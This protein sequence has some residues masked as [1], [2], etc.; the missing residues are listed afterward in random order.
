[1]TNTELFKKWNEVFISYFF[2]EDME[3]DAEISLFIDKDT[4]NELGQEYGLGG[5][6]GFISIIMLS[7]EERQEVY[8]EL[9]KC[10]INTSLSKEQRLKL[11]SKNIF[12]FS[13]IYID[14]NF[15]K[16]VDCPFLIYIVFIVLMG[17]ECQKN[18]KNR[19]A[20]GNYITDEL[21]KHFPNHN[22]DRTAFK[23]LFNA[24]ADQH[25]QFHA[26]GITEHPYIGLIKYQLGLSKKQVELLTKAMY[27]ADLSEEL[28]Y[29][30]WIRKIRDYVDGQ[31][32]DL[33]DKSVDEM[34]LKKRISDLRSNFDPIQ[35]ESIHQEEDIIQKGKFVLAI[36]EDDYSEEED[37]LVVLTD[38][39]NKT[40]SGGNIKIT[41]GTID[42]LGEYAEYNVNHVLI[43]GCDKAQM[44]TYSLKDG[45]NRVTS[46]SLG[47]I[48]TFSRCSNN[49]LI[50]TNFPQKGKETY[51]LVRN[52]HQEE[53]EQWLI[54]HDSPNVKE[55]MSTDR[56]LQI[57]GKGWNLFISNEIEIVDKAKSSSHRSSIIMEG[58]IRCIGK[59]KVYLRTGL[60]YFEFPEPIDEN[61][62][63]IFIAIENQGLEDEEYNYMIV[64]DNRLVIDLMNTA[65]GDHSLDIGI[66]LEYKIG[67]GKKL[68]FHEDFSVIGQDIRYSED[69]LFKMNMWGGISTEENAP[70]MKGIKVVNAKGQTDIPEGTGFYQNRKVDL[71]IHDRRFYLV[72]LIAA[73]CSMRR[74]FSITEQRLKKCIRYAATRFDINIAS[75]STFYTD[76]KYLL[77]NSGYINVDFER[78]K[79]QPVPPAF[80]KTA[81]GFDPGNNLFMLVGS[82]TQKFLC[83]LKNYCRDQY[84]SIYLHKDDNSLSKGEA[85]IPPVILLQ[86]NFS[87]DGFKK[88]TKSMFLN[89]YN[90]DVAINILKALPSYKDYESSLEHV[91]PNVFDPRIL[92][93]PDCL[94]FPRVRRSKATGYSSST[95]IE[96]SNN[97]YYRVTI[98]D[99]AWAYLYCPYKVQKNIYTK[100]LDKLL[101]PSKL[102]LPVMMQRALYILNFGVPEKVKA[103]ICQNDDGNS[104]YYNVIKRYHI[105][106]SISQTRM[107]LVIRA[108]TGRSD[109]EQNSSI[110]HRIT[111]YNKLFIWKNRNRSSKNYR[112]L[113]VLTD[114][115][116]REIYGFGTKKGMKSFEIYLRM[117]TSENCFNL[118]DNDNINEV[119][120]KILKS[121]W[122]DMMIKR[123]LRDQEK[124]YKCIGVRIAN[125]RSVQPPPREEYEIE[126]IQII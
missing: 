118:V 51:I 121:N 113:L 50:Q 16:Y 90:E 104:V 88:K 126:E 49:Y 91:S 100:D 14:S 54:K 26:E 107:P 87:P 85:L 74:D 20:I 52:G 108:I 93:T 105:K 2:P 57:F 7:E 11:N 37:R 77:L 97:D 123:I 53:W 115:T 62:L 109:N 71:D 112:S 15:Y 110:R 99:L 19:G 84:V 75:E 33:L 47:N 29:D 40:I 59:N 106:D 103:F 18:N 66:T 60:P 5:Y 94:D 83:D 82:Y 30:M 21:K 46:M 61:K 27:R 42:R 63:E 119:F 68:R 9:W 55:E 76:V 8:K 114:S 31:M 4:I 72:N 12:D 69:V 64:D 65:F 117:Y 125:E 116:G 6:D 41:K 70:Y 28:P 32:K 22:N 78:G 89:A 45:G 35:Y 43:G 23:Q 3:E 111:T 81:A 102:H 24:L 58:G 38:V 98:P 10:Y 122:A 101:F 56:K 13:T 95:W 80:L 92:E 67:K 39:N 96:K 36:Y 120:S 48:V 44:K 124:I 1:M 86:H 25:P 34:V 17:S 73:E 79:Y